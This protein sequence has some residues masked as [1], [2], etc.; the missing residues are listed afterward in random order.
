MSEIRVKPIKPL[1]ETL[2]A[3][4]RVL[5]QQVPDWRAYSRRAFQVDKIAV[6]FLII[7]GWVATSAYL[8]AGDWTAVM[9][10]L[11]WAIPPAVGVL[12]LLGFTA[13]LYARTSVYTITNKR[14]VIQSGVAIPSSVN[15][16]FAKVGSADLKT[17]RDG[18]GDIE[19]TMSGPRLLYSMVWPNVRFLRLKRPTPVLR[20]VQNPHKVADTLGAALT[21]DQGA[22]A[23]PRTVAR[24][25]RTKSRSAV[26]S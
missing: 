11:L 9:R 13:W 25:P 14:I 23:A 16:P 19:L 22:E 26:T 5:W 12:V 3:G 4:E 8:D 21:A 10:S 24:E 6:Y 15:L 2:P 1:P 17:F 20:G 18:T 7:V